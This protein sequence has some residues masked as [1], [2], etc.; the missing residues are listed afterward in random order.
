[1]VLRDLVIRGNLKLLLVQVDPADQADHLDPLV[2]DLLY[3]P[4]DLRTQWVLVD[5]TVQAVHLV[6]V[7]QLVLQIQVIQEVLYLL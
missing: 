4:A 2:L 7:H 5:L 3:L 1:L 6:Q